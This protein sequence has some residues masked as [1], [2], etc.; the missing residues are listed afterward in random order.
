MASGNAHLL[1]SV[2]SRSYTV[3]TV[4]GVRLC[5]ITSEY[6]PSYCSTKELIATLFC[7]VL[8]IR[9]HLNGLNHPVIGDF[10]HGDRHFN[11]QFST[12][13]TAAAGEFLLY[14]ASTYIKLRYNCVA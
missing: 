4:E 13:H 1:H 2:F 12:D 11:R 9:R 10:A 7:A 8:Q 6:T 5:I 14:N 3:S